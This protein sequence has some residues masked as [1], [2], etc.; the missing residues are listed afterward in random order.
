MYWCLIFV[1]KEHGSIYLSLHTAYTLNWV[2][3][4]SMRIL[5]KEAKLSSR[6]SIELF[7]ESSYLDLSRSY[8]GL[9]DYMTSRIWNSSW[10]TPS[11]NFGRSVN[12]IVYLWNTSIQMVE[13]VPDTNRKCFKLWARCKIGAIA[14]LC[15]S[16]FLFTFENVTFHFRKKSSVTLSPINFNLKFIWGTNKRSS[17]S[18]MS[19]GH[20]FK[21]YTTLNYGN[22]LNST[23]C[24]SGVGNQH[25]QWIHGGVFIAFKRGLLCTETPELDT[26]CEIVWCKLNIIGCRTLYLGS[27]YSFCIS[28][29]NKFFSTAHYTIKLWKMFSRQNTLVSP[30]QI[31]WIG[32]SMAQKS[33]PKQL[34]HLVSF[35]GI[36]LLHLG[37]Q[38]KL[39]TKLWFSLN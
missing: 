39:H 16:Y 19:N 21:A 14:Y 27:F 33:L 3:R 12:T 4:A 6:Y 28:I 7:L 22:S 32:V 30:L 35:A 10:R 31:T 25:W 26:N 17:R 29:T 13:G 2:S 8:S 34:R 9:C 1:F 23:T 36:W 24:C 37:V 18:E 5:K 38:R 20:Y 11:N 15:T